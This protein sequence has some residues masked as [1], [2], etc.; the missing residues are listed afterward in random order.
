M[1]RKIK[2]GGGKTQAGVVSHLVVGLEE[3]PSGA[4]AFV[5][6]SLLLYNGRVPV[7]ELVVVVVGPLESGTLDSEMEE[8]LDEVVV[9]PFPSITI[10]RLSLRGRDKLNPCGTT[11]RAKLD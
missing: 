8:G 11:C 1:E 10:P 2:V 4:F 9:D 5:L 6:P 3:M 7:V